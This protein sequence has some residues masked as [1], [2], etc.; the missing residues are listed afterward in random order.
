MSC[1]LFFPIHSFLQVSRVRLSNG[2]YTGPF[3]MIISSPLSSP[4]SRACP[5]FQ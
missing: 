3:S 2:S 4:V 1:Q 5:V